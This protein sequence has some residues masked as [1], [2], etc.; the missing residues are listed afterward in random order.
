MRKAILIVL[1]LLCLSGCV[2]TGKPYVVEEQKKSVIQ[3]PQDAYFLAGDTLQSIAK[4]PYEE[5]SV[6][7]YATDELEL[8]KVI[9]YEL[10]IGNKQ[11]SYQSENDLDLDQVS[12]YLSL[13]NPFDLSI[14]QHIVSYSNAQDE[15][16]Y[17][18]YQIDFEI[19]DQ[20]Y[21]ESLRYAKETIR[22]LITPTMS[23]NEKIKVIHDTIIANCVYD[24]AAQKAAN[25]KTEVFQAGGVFFDQKAVCTGY[26]RAFMMLAR[27][28][29]IPVV[30]A[31]SKS[32]NHSWNYVYDGEAWRYVDA[33]WDDHDER[34]QAIDTTFLNMSEQEFLE[35]G[36]HVLSDEEQTQIHLMAQT[37]YGDQ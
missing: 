1:C 14:T 35:E 13:I 11:I 3:V 36:S 12:E 23:E 4:S 19:L 15:V 7:Y 33:T 16:L 24:I 32:M 20:R 2:Q 25:A 21:E 22:S 5:A 8:A 31:S 28:A 29:Q 27:E 10:E 37:F 6:V 34:S 18:S 30:Y 26:S 17:D 9:Q